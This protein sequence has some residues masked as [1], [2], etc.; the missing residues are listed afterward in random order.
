MPFTPY[1]LGF[2]VFTYS[3]IMFLDPVALLLGTILIDI[4]PFFILVL[5]LN[6]P[7][8]GILHSFLGVIILIFPVSF[9]SQFM[10]RFFLGNFFKRSYSWKISFFSSF[11]GLF[12]H[13]VFDSFLYPEIMF[14]YPFSTKEAIFYGIMSY[15]TASS[16]LSYFFL[17]GVIILA[18]RSLFSL[19]K[20]GK[21]ENDIE[22]E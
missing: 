4:E 3:L 7:L 14:F 15:Q 13:L 8:H 17:V 22:R 6:L 21:E 9:I 16:I 1:H 18:L 19:M 2:G 20:K 10:H 12:S 5:G 11:I